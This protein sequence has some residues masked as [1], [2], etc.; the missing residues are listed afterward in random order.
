MKQSDL[1]SLNH[2]V[3]HWVSLCLNLMRIQDN[4]SGFLLIINTHLFFSK[5]AT[6]AVI[7]LRKSMDTWGVQR[8]PSKVDTST[9]SGNNNERETSF[10][11]KTVVTIRGVICAR[12]K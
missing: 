10:N 9:R 6:I 2:Y 7:L 5:T 1:C 8:R 12:N 11:D 3:P 4:V